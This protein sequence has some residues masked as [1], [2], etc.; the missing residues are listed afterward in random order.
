MAQ[1]LY[2]LFDA[3]AVHVELDLPRQ[4]ED[5]ECGWVGLVEFYSPLHLVEQPADILEEELH[6][7]DDGPV[8]SD[9]IFLHDIVDGDEIIRSMWWGGKLWLAGSRLT[10][11]AALFP[12]IWV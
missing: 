3:V 6:R 8:G 7:V 1:L 9:L 2:D 5:Q 4:V 10:R 12:N 11:T